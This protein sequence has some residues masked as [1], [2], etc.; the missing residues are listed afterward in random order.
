MDAR[1][2]AFGGLMLAAA[3]L[4]GGCQS[5]A[6]APQDMARTNLG[7]APADL[8]LMCASAAA[9]PSGVDSSKILPTSSSQLDATSYRVDLDAAWACVGSQV[10]IQGNLDP[11]ALLAS[12]AEIRR[13]AKAILDR[14]A[15]RPGHIFNLGHGILPPTPVDHAIALVDAVHELSAR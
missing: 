14:A 2:I 8:Q 7:T 1:G 11:V 9:G 10:G 3:G 12:P 4:A 15:G 6:P 5:S 13:Q